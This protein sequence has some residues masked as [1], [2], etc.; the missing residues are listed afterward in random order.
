MNDETIKKPQLTDQLWGVVKGID[1]GR[2][3]TGFYK[4][5]KIQGTIITL[6]ISYELIGWFNMEIK[7]YIYSNDYALDLLRGFFGHRYKFPE[8][9]DFFFRF[10]PYN[11]IVIKSM[12]LS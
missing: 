5:L 11:F 9:Y 7:E 3:S 6:E 8:H 1:Y 2:L 4:S 10:G 12:E